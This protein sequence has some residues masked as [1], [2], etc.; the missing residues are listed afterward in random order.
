MY[1]VIEDASPYYI[2]FKFEGLE[3][4]I[5]FVRS[6][7]DFV[8]RDIKD[9]Y[10]HFDFNLPTAEQIVSMLPMSSTFDFMRKRVAIFSTPP[11]AASGIHK[12][13][14][15]TRVS[16]NIPI[17]ILDNHCLTRW[18]DDSSFTD[19][20][21]T[22]MPY[23]RHVMG[24]LNPM[25]NKVIPVKEMIAQPNEMIL[26]NTDI[27]HSWDNKDSKNFRKILTLRIHNPKDLKFEDVSKML[28]E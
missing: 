15:D 1:T 17:E 10:K 25:Y 13:G 16:F 3:Q 23:S 6:S 27:F 12:D 2:R 26:F 9:T 5:D 4:I 7:T 20:P 22:K 19:I 21:L 11:G 8:E 28:F 24:F 18:F 14:V